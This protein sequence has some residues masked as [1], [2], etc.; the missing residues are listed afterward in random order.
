MAESRKMKT[1]KGLALVP[2]ANPLADGCNFAVEVPEDSRASLILYKKRSAKPYVE[3]PFTEENRTG[4]VYAM[5][6]PDFDL[7]EYEYNFLINGKVY[8]DPCAYKILGRERFGAEVGTNPHK[9]RGGFLKKEVFDWENDKN[10]AIPYH[11][12]ILYKLHMNLWKAVPV[13]ILNLRKWY[14]RS[15]HRDVLISG[16]ICM[17]IILHPRDLTVQQMIR[18]KSLKHSLKNCIRPELPVS[19][20]CIFHEN[21][22]L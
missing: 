7:K 21:V 2:G 22:I 1:E 20:K 10:P 11:E 16:D 4:N 3:I 15:I 19:W 13:R 12:M 18:R 9:V 8:T 6:I 5:Y 17:A 14:L